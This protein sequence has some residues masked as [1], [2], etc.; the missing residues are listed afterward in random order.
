[1]TLQDVQVVSREHERLDRKY[2][3]AAIDENGII[4]KMSSLSFL[5]I[6]KK[7]NKQFRIDVK[8]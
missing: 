1:M 3:R 6:F 5:F 4:L 7:P 8:M 2:F